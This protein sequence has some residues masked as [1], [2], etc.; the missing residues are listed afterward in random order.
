[1]KNLIKRGEIERLQ[2]EF[3]NIKS[4]N[5]HEINVPRMLDTLEILLKEP[6]NVDYAELA[7]KYESLLFFYK[8]QITDVKRYKRLL[9]GLM[10]DM[11]FQIE[12]NEKIV[13]ARRRIDMKDYYVEVPVVLKLMVGVKA[14]NE[15][16]AIEKVFN[17]DIMIKAE[18]GD[19]S[20]L[21]WLEYEWEM[22][23][24]VVQGNVYYGGINEAYAEEDE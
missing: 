15:K 4:T 13:L 17:E 20:T 14:E 19:N 24:K 5:W 1:M 10:E 18:E 7:F 11:D 6:I 8:Q 12:E 2:K 21:E 9:S 3:A 22:Y 16:D 23:S